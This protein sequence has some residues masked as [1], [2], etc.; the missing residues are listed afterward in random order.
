MEPQ[1]DHYIGRTAKSYNNVD[2]NL[3][4]ELDNGPLDPIVITIHDMSSKLPINGLVLVSADT[5]K[6]VF[7]QPSKDLQN[8]QE[9][10]VESRDVTIEDPRYPEQSPE[11]DLPPDPSAERVKDGPDEE[12]AEPSG[13]SGQ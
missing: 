6:I 3:V 4:I 10:L 9:I 7:A 12:E 13:E 8:V 11:E 2:G 1:V 5:D